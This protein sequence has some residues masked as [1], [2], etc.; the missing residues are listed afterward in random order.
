MLG[1]DSQTKFYSMSFIVIYHF[2]EDQYPHKYVYVV[3][4]PVSS[5]G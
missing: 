3:G 5:V 1:S 4:Q 2:S